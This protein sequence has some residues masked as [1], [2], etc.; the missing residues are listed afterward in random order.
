MKDNKAKIL[1]IEDDPFLL[2]MYSQKFE[3]EGFEVVMA[4]NGKDGLEIAKKEKPDLILLDVLIPHLNGFNVLKKLKESKE[5]S[6]IPVVILT[7]LSQQEEVKQ[8][9]SMGAEEYL[10]KAHHVPSEIVEKVRDVLT[11][12]IK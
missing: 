8:G 7:N 3:L 4:S 5:T 6:E 11:K 2:G 9:L 1:L 10:I 12:K